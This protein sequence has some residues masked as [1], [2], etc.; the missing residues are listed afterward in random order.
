M[1]ATPEVYNRRADESVTEAVVRAVADVQGVKPWEMDSR[2]GDA[3]DPEALERLCGDAS[4]GSRE[5]RVSFVFAG[6]R[7]AADAAG[8][9]FVTERTPDH[10]TVTTERAIRRC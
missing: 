3:I 1:T 2:L 4:T 10:A 6:Y 7:V 5:T 8:A 9:V